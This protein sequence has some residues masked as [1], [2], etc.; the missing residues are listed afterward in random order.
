MGWWPHRLG[1][2]LFEAV[3]LPRVTCVV[4]V[5]YRPVHA[6]L[7]GRETVGLE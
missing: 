7:T 1:R 6:G 4:V 2:P 5:V 3:G